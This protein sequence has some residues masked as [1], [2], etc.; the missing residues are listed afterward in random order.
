M[1]LFSMNEPLYEIQTGRVPFLPKCNRDFELFDTNNNDN[2]KFKENALGNIQQASPLSYFFFDNAN[3]K[4]VND[5]I[6]YNVYIRSGKKHIIAPQSVTEL[7]IIMRGIF[8]QHSFGQATNIL[9]QIEELNDIVVNYATPKILSEIE[10]YYGYMYD[11]ENMP[12]PID[13]PIA[14]NSRGTKTLRSVTSTF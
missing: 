14:L 4:R 9:A 12:T 8:L 5:K 10:Q 6:R 11:V 1:S 2:N 7:E 3:I 13:L